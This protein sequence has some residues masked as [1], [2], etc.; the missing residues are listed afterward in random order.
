MQA[1]KRTEYQTQIKL[2]HDKK[3]FNVSRKNGAQ[4]KN[5]FFLMYYKTRC[6]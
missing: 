1:E 5:V 2:K 4:Q 6:L 3:K